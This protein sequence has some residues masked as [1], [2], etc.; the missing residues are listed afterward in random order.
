ME[1]LISVIP[2][3]NNG[4][5]YW[6]L[7]GKSLVKTDLYKFWSAYDLYSTDNSGRICQ[8]YTESDSVFIIIGKKNG[9]S[10]LVI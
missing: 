7:L 1:S 10:L 3:Y 6:V 8:E 9:V 4:K 2:V 5:L